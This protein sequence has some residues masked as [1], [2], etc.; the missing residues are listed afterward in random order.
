VAARGDVVLD[1]L[2]DLRQTPA[3]GD[4]RDSAGAPHA[5]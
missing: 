5:L 3:G 2:H 4:L 1:V